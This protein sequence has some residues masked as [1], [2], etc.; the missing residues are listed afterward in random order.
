M[1]TTLDTSDERLRFQFPR[2]LVTEQSFGRNPSHYRAKRVRGCVT[3][4]ARIAAHNLAAPR[5]TR[6]DS[7]SIIIGDFRNERH[8]GR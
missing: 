7:L 5:E 8:R 3:L 1:K 4:E 2:N 6:L